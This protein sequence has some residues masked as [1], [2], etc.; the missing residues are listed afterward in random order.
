MLEFC[1]RRTDGTIDEVHLR[2]EEFSLDWE[3]GSIGL[4]FII[5]AL[6]RVGGWGVKTPRRSD[7]IQLWIK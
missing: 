6:C 4:V 7:Q 2:F 3:T 5:R 1:I